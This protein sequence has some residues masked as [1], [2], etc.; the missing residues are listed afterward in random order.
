MRAEVANADAAL[1]PGQFVRVVLRGAQRK[2]ALAVPQ[3]AVLDGPQ[4]K[5]VYVVAKDKDGKDVASQRTVVVGDWV[6]SN[7]TNLWQIESGLKAGDVVIVD[8]I[9]RLQPGAPIKIAAAAPAG[10]AGAAPAPAPAAAGK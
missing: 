4:G 7:G 8:G 10:A 5:F 9:A 3:V 1:K 2:N 6:D